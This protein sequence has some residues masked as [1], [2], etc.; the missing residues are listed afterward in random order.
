MAFKCGIDLVEVNRIKCSIEGEHGAS[1][2]RRVFTDKEIAYCNKSGRPNYQSYA[3][4]FAAKEA[5]AKAMGTGICANVVMNEI[6]V[7]NIEEGIFKG[8]T[9][10]SLSGRTAVY[11][12][13]Y[14]GGN[15]EIS[16]SH[17]EGLAQAVCIVEFD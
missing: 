7:C 4:R 14:A 3:A 13:E 16:L 8:K 5:F 12:E 1:F 17:T 11:F 2:L 10:I 6:E 9:Y 15:I